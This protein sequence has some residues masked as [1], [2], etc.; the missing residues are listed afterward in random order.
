[1]APTID[2]HGGYS[3]TPANQTWDQVKIPR[4][5]V[6]YH[7]SSNFEKDNWKQMAKN[8]KHQRLLT[9]Y[10]SPEE[11]YYISSQYHKLCWHKTLRKANAND[12]RKA[13]IPYRDRRTDMVNL[14]RWAG[15]IMIFMLAA[16]A[17]RSGAEVA[18]WTLDRRIRV[19]FPAY[20]HRVW[21]LWWQGGKRRLL[22]SRCPCR[23]RLGTLKTLAAHGVGARHQVKIWK[24]DT[25]PVTI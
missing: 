4:D 8:I 3:R 10:A 15:G 23:G 6:I 19:R 25:C 2:H 12:R 14:L 9:R 13:D 24:L 16:T 7:I 1:M 17:R 22:T 20:P 18:G 5:K 21:A 11:K